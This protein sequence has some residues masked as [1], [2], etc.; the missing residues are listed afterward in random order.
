MDSDSD[1]VRREGLDA[2]QSPDP[3]E[4]TDP[5]YASAYQLARFYALLSP[6]LL[7]R[8]LEIDRARAERLVALLAERDVLGPVMI[9]HS[10]AR[11]SRVNIILEVG[12]QVDLSPNLVGSSRR[13]A[14]LAVVVTG[15][16]VALGLGACVGLVTL[17]LGTRLASA[18][19]LGF[20]SPALA[21]VAGL[22]ILPAAAGALLAFLVESVL[23]PDEGQVS[24]R[25][26]EVRRGLWTLYALVALGY[27]SLQ[28]FR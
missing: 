3:G 5:L 28:L 7:Q 12:S 17:G 25:A 22:L 19:G 1:S 16:G 24:Y 11:E 23:S 27:G 10:G 8:E 20:I 2:P 6:G 4:P 9:A 18:L 21:D 14:G 15:I 13:T 26:T